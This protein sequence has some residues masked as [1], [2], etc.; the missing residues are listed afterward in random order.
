MSVASISWYILVFY[1]KLFYE[2]TVSKTGP[3]APWHNLVASKRIEKLPKIPKICPRDLGLNW[4]SPNLR[5]CKSITAL[6]P[7]QSF[8]TIHQRCFSSSLKG[9]ENLYTKC[10][11]Q[12]WKF[13][14]LLLNIFFVFKH[15]C[16]CFWEHF[17]FFKERGAASERYQ[18]KYVT[19]SEKK[20]C[21]TVFEHFLCWRKCVTASENYVHLRNVLKWKTA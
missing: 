10:V 16:G 20:T 13:E 3:K 12:P 14:Q 7:E 18:V 1:Y 11:Q 9:H 15:M 21:T 5:R 17:M 6:V 4:G 2:S 8:S 19:A